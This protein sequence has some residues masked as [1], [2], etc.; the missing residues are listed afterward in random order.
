MIRFYD[1]IA[2]TNSTCNRSCDFT[3]CVIGFHEGEEDME[4]I[5][6]KCSALSEKWSITLGSYYLYNLGTVGKVGAHGPICV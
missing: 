4:H 1:H 6:C 5:Y 2:Y 3:N